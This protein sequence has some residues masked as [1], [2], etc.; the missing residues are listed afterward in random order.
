MRKL[1]V[2]QPKRWVVLQYRDL[3]DEFDD[4]PCVTAFVIAR[5]EAESD[6]EA[7]A[8]RKFGREAVFE[9]GDVRICED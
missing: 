2:P 3:S 9:S 7:W 6:A 4:V 5:F 1:S 8:T